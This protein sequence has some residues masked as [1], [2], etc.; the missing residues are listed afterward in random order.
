M[1]L[2]QI[3]DWCINEMRAPADS[4]IY[5]RAQAI[6]RFL[7]ELKKERIL[8]QRA[9]YSLRMADEALRIK[10]ELID[11]YRGKYDRVKP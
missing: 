2:D 8:R 4:D 1:M 10:D 5:H 3:E 6:L 7:A 11:A 9:E